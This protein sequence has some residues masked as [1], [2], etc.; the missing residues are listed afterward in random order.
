M[1]AT[2]QH[3]NKVQYGGNTL[4]DLTG[5]DVQR[6]DVRAGVVFHLP[7]GEQTTGTGSG[8]GGVGIHQ[9][10]DGYLVL[11][12]SGDG[13]GDGNPVAVQKQINFVDYDGAIRYS[14]TAAEFAE[15]EELPPNPTHEGKVAQGWNWTLAQI[16]AQLTDC[17]DGDVWVGQQYTTTDGKTHIRIV[18]PSGVPDSLR[19]FNI[20]FN[21]SDAY[22]VQ[23]DWGDSSELESHSST[24]QSLD[25]MYASPGVYDI[26]LDVV[27]GTIS[28]PYAIFRQDD[29]VRNR[30]RIID[31]AFGNGITS[32]GEYVLYV[33]YSH[34][35]VSVPSGISSSGYYMHGSSYGLTTSII[36][37]GTTSVAER[38]YR[39]GYGLSMVSIPSGVTSIGLNA[40]YENYGLR[41][42]TIPSGVTSIGDNAFVSCHSLV[43]ISIPSSVSSIGSSAF[44][45]CTG[46]RAYHFRATTPPTLGSSAF[47]SIP[48]DCIIYVPSA[49]VNSYKSATNWSSYSSYIQGE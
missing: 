7:S 43:S 13:G 44:S 16:S 47:S 42:V 28:F 24:S 22:G 20:R 27:S 9:D 23:V 15:L 39:Y 12:P 8:G 49:S 6:S 29:I 30:G 41:S 25:H 21:Q 36:S 31:I 26:A 45:G 35:T 48:S 19:I 4:I 18:M 1:M 10:Q 37:S 2:N 40:F 38:M 14:Y 32:F 33:I 5:D 46:M 11:D 3:V 17:P 34:F